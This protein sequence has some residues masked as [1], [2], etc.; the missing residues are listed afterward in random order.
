MGGG[1][2]GPVATS[3]LA[4]PFMITEGSAYVP[5]LIEIDGKSLMG[6]AK[7]GVLPTEIYAYAIGEDGTVGDFFT[8]ALGLDLAKVRP[9]LEQSGFK[10]W[11]HFELEPGEYSVRVLVRNGLSGS[12]GL[13]VVD[14]TVPAT[15]ES[16]AALLPPLF[17]EPQGKWLLG[18]DPEQPDVD[19]PFM[20][21]EQP[22]IPAA[23]PVLRPGQAQ[24]IALVGYNLGGNSLAVEGRLVGLDGTPV[25]CEMAIQDRPAQAFPGL[26]RMMAS[27]SAGSAAAG[28]YRLEVTV[29]DTASGQTQ[30]SSIPVRVEG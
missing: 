13:R 25:A 4:P 18:R 12:S 2:G 5:V 24:Q 11:G 7:S 26:D 21:G 16:Q 30:T 17:P 19:Y 10:F 6:A 29:T 1:E 3:V 28:P 8:Q 9:A 20:I 23:R 22:F 14:V 15:A 27:L